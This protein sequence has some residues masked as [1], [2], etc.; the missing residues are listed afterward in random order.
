MEL[1]EH[2]PWVLHYIRVRVP[3]ELVTPCSGLALALPVLLPR[4]AGVV[5]AVAVELHGQ[6]MLRPAAIDTT[7]ARRAVGDRK[8]ERVR[9]QMLEK[10]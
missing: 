9:A 3:A 8:G 10:P 4:V 7:P 1:I 5:E 2:G 6:A